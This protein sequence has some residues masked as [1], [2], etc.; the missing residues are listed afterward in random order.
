[1]EER[2]IILIV[3]DGDPDL[4]QAT[5]NAI[6]AASAQGFEVYGIGIDAPYMSRLLPPKHSLQ[7]NSLHELAPAMFDILR[8]ALTRQNK[9]RAA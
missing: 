2:K 5:A 7:V 1:H 8:N 6:K 3:S 4:P 9:G